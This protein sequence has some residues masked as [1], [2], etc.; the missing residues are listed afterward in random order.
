MPGSRDA[1]GRCP[2][3]FRSSLKAAP[4]DESSRHYRRIDAVR[5]RIPPACPSTITD[6]LGASGGWSRAP[7]T[8]NH[9]GKEEVGHGKVPECTVDG[10]AGDRRRRLYNILR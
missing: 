4:S 7:G 1:D 3:D 9:T 6:D 8:L 2:R 10:R 5:G